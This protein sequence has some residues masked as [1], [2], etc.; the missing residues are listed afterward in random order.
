MSR[1]MA[2]FDSS[3][4]NFVPFCSTPS[5]FISPAFTFKNQV[6]P[7]NGN[8]CRATDSHFSNK[9]K[10]LNLRSFHQATATL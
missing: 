10:P 5:L 1:Q 8:Q 3:F 2:R 6:V 7:T 4:V 9:P